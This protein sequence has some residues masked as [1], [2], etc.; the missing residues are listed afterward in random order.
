MPALAAGGPAVPE[1]P[2][3][4]PL[5]FRQ[6]VIIGWPADGT[7]TAPPGFFVTRFAE[8]LDHPRWLYVL[9]NGDVLVAQARTESMGG[10]PDEVI[11]ELT[12]QGLF[13][14]SPDNII[15]LC[16]TQSGVT[17]H[18]FIEGLNQPFGMALSGDSLLVANTNAL[19]KF[20]YRTGQTHI[21]APPET[22]L[23]IPAGEQSGHWNNHWTRNVVVSPDGQSLYL[24]V[25]AATNNNENGNE[26]P[27]RAAIW[28]LAVDGRGKTMFATGLRNP[29]GMDF[30]P[31]TGDLWTTVNERDGL[32]ED[33][34]PDYLTRVV[35]GAFYGWPY[36]YFGTYPDPTHE[37][38]NPDRG[39]TAQA[40]ARVPDVAV[41]A[42]SVPLG[43]LFYRGEQFPPAYR[44]GAFV[45]RR[46]GVSRAQFIGIDVIFVGFEHG[47]AQHFNPFLTGFVADYGKGTVHGRPVGLAMLPDGSLLVADDSAGIIWRVG[48]GNNRQ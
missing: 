23:D 13:G 20:P 39:L 16:N 10:F 48:F 33:V 45:A 46:G 19:L 36:V 41:G 44:S 5:V 40:T 32:G 25:G 9:P 28:R 15:L 2:P 42:H 37:R 38:L 4:G 3:P 26:H 8:G 17:S 43:L 35:E 6:P 18:L 11:A 24:S 7:P 12:K 22:L 1:L 21:D 30:D 34:P 29:V 47:Q 31:E 27:E 14:K